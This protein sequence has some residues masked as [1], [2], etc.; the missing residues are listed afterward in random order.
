MHVSIGVGLYGCRAYPSCLRVGGGIQP[1]QLPHTLQ[2]IGIFI[3]TVETYTV[4]HVKLSLVCRYAAVSSLRFLSFILLSLLLL[5]TTI[6]RMSC[7]LRPTVLESGGLGLMLRNYRPN[8]SS[9]N[10]LTLRC[11][12]PIKSRLAFFLDRWA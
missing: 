7:G 12:G 3:K 9:W 4:F 10:S 2:I 6:S 1:G 11:R 5:W 8:D